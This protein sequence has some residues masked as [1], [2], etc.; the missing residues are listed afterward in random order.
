MVGALSALGV[1]WANI[2]GQRQIARDNALRE[3]RVA[4]VN[5]L[6]ERADRRLA[7]FTAVVVLAAKPTTSADAVREALE[8]WRDNGL[9]LHGSGFFARRAQCSESA[10]ESEFKAAIEQ[11]TTADQ[12]WVNATF[13]EFQRNGAAGLVS[14]AGDEQATFDR[15]LMRAHAA[16]VPFIFG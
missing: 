16:A 13:E 15:A 1:A 6:F 2:R 10:A 4:R 11:L 5:A 14:G 3:Y 8:Q 12:A 7:E 9:A